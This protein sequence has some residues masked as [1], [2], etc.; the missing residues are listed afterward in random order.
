M[1]KVV[2]STREIVDVDK[3]IAKVTS[4]SKKKNV[5]KEVKKSDQTKKSTKNVKTKKTKEKKDGYF[6]EVRSEMSKVKWLGKKDMVKYSVA[7]IVFIIFFSV[8]FLLINVVMAFL[9]AMV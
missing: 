4:D 7:S 2:K 1:A 6:K 8:F 5:K 3:E 9:K